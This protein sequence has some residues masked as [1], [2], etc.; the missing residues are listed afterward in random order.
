MHR[1]LTAADFPSPEALRRLGRRVECFDSIDSTNR[2]LLRRAAELP[3]GTIATAEFQSA[4]RGRLGRTW[5]A[6]RGSSV[7]LSI[8]LHEPADSTL[9]SDASLLLS[10]ATC[11]AI[12]RTT[13]CHPAV[14]WPNDLTVGGRK[15]AGVLAETSSLAGGR[16]AV[17]AGVGLNC[18]QHA[19]HFD[20]SLRTKATSLELECTEAVDRSALAAAIVARADFWLAES[21]AGRQ[22][23]MRQAWLDRCADRGTVV[24]LEENGRTLCGTVVDVDSTGNLVVQLDSGMR[25]SFE[26][27]TTTRSW[28]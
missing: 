8:L 25:R 27:A 9:P 18:L 21:A 11:E 4:G 3:D 16:R 20:E 17:V 28:E 5:G 22:E 24:R 15:L 6:P 14:R 13:S 12:E 2:H 10:V 23:S 19:G 1:P 26:A 7:L